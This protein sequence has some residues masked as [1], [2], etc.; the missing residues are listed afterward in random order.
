[1][2][3]R[4]SRLFT[5]PENLYAIGSP[6]VIAAGTLLKD[7]QTGKIV[8][9]LKL[10]SISEKCIRA[11]KVR[12]NLFD[13]AG[14]PIGNSVEYEYLDLNATRDL[15]FG[16]KNP[17]FVSESKARS[18]EAAVVEVVFADR[19]TWIASEDTWEP[20]SVPTAIRS[21][22][23]AEFA[24]QFCMEYGEHCKYFPMSEK[25]LWRCTCG[26]L[27]H[28]QEYLCHLCGEAF[29]TISRY[30]VDEL[31]QHRNDRLAYE[32]EKTVAER[33]AKK[34]KAKLLR[35]VISTLCAVIAIAL[36]VT[37]VIIPNGKYNDAVALMELGLYEDAIAAFEAIEGY[38]DSKE[39]AFNCEQA[40]LDAQFAEAEALA[41]SGEIA[42]AALAFDRLGNYKD[43]RNRSIEMWELAVQRATISASRAHTLGLMA[44]G[45]VVAVGHQSWGQ[46]NVSAWKD[47]VEISAGSFHSIGL[48]SD[49][50]VVAA[51]HNG[52]GQCNVSSW[53]G[54]VAISTLRE[55]T[56]GLKSDGSVV[57]TGVNKD[58]QCDVISWQNIVAISAGGSHTVGLMVDGTVVA[59]G[60]N[61]AG[62]CDVSAWSDIV[63]VS[64]G[65]GHTVGLKSDGTVVAVGYN[66][67]GRC[68]VDTWQDIVSI[69]AGYYYTVGL[70]SDGTV[71][72]VG[73][74]DDDQC[75]I[76]SW[77]DIVAICVGYHHI[78]GLKSD[79][80]VVTTGENDE[81]QCD[82][83][84]WTNIVP[85]RTGL[86]HTVGPQVDDAPDVS[87]R[88][89]IE[90]PNSS[91]SHVCEECGNN[92]MN[93]YKNPFSGKTEYYCETHYQE[94]KSIIGMMEDDVKNSSQSNQNT[95]KNSYSGSSARHTDS[96]AFSCAKA[97]VKSSLKSPSTAK[98]C[99]IT[100]AT[101]THLGNGEYKVTGWVEAQNSFGATLRQTFVVV[102]TATENGYK[103]GTATLS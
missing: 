79:G 85:F 24:K 27:N 43:A 75:D 32:K 12:L 84:Q 9:Q 41:E 46:C 56:V 80:T 74:L 25:D 39:Q 30:N 53:R 21:V 77:Q 62:Q 18:Y 60:N 90:R 28:R 64:A 71:V 44:D 81:G 14:N 10:R 95:N 40:I 83:S 45:K 54:I 16:Q 35:I 76:S 19:T 6:V 49:G 7:N 89:D 1:M 100:D 69:S 37:K 36:L 65:G 96:E 33:A 82:A 73:D 97:I 2:S 102:Y 50:M 23:D 26:A 58:G 103:N 101:I 20:L 86:A 38:K 42:K 88:T 13:T 61:G 31:K 99:W 70:K 48:K 98:F 52:S 72:A 91:N 92:A 66:D 68:D 51:G 15:E 5:L 29:A 87:E 93:T 3:E 59:V 67:D 78:I 22:H 55:H 63:A 34:K 4:Y 11:V 8:A 47:I 17:I 94:I 57:A